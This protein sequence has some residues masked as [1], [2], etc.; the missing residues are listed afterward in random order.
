MECFVS[1]IKW[2]VVGFVISP[3][4]ISVIVYFVT[5]NNLERAKKFVD[6]VAK[7][8]NVLKNG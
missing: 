1:G 6:W 4:V 5:K 8:V 3:I 2:F 7:K